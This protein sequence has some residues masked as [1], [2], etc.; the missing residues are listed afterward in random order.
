M[1]HGRMH[2]RDKKKMERYNFFLLLSSMVSLLKYVA[3][4]DHM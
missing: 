4:F 1:N 3:Q 2:G